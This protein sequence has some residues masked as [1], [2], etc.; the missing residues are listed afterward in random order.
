MPTLGQA[1]QQQPRPTPA[2]WTVTVTAGSTP[3][4]V[5]TA[6]GPIVNGLWGTPPVGKRVVVMKV[7]GIDVAIAL[8][9]EA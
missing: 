4:T 7:E 6:A 3:T 8:I 9:G 5:H 1:L 2:P